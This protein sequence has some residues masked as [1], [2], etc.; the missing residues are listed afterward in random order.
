MA[1]TATINTS[2]GSKVIVPG[3]GIVLNNEMDD[4]SSAPG[5][6]NAFGL[7]GAENNA[8]ASGETSPFQHEPD[9]R[10]RQARVRP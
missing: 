1:I 3:T 6:A 7:I 8:V 9:D 2:F 5:V 10:A 4:F